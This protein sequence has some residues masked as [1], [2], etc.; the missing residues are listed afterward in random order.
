MARKQARVDRTEP[1]HGLL[2]APGSLSPAGDFSD[3]SK[4]LGMMASI[5]ETPFNERQAEAFARSFTDRTLLIWGPPGTGKTTVLA[6]IVLGWLERAWV[7]NKPICI[8]VGSSNYNAIDKVL[9]DIWEL[10]ARRIERIGP[11]T[12]ATRIVRIRSDSAAPLNEPWVQNLS[13]GELVPVEIDRLLAKP[14]ECLIVGGTWMQ[15]A[16]LA[17]AASPEGEPIAR[18]FDLLILD[19]ASQIKVT[20]A[21]AYYLLLKPTANVVHAG[22]HRQLGPIHGFP[23]REDGEGLFDCIFT[24]L[25]RTHGLQPVA[26]NQNYRTNREISDWPRERFYNSGY[27][28]FVPRRR[29]DLTFPISRSGAPADW[30]ESLPWSEVYYR[31]LDPELP[32]VVVRYEAQTFTLSNPFEA[33]QV[34][35]LTHLYRLLL[36]EQDG[37]GLLD[38]FWKERLGIVTPHRAQMSGIRNLI[39]N[40]AGLPRDQP[41]AVDTVDRFQG[42]ERDVIIASYAVSDRDF[43][44]SEEEFILDPRRFNVTL[45]RARSKFVMFISDALIEHLPSDAQL[46]RDAAHLQLFVENYC[47]TVDEPIELPFL[48]SEQVVIMRCR[49]KGRRLPEVNAARFR[50]D[51][52]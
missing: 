50:G 1:A 52:R 39:I 42:Q 8:G 43:V 9:R 16:K 37:Q 46:A 28:A 36:A 6:G 31:I 47:S 20:T 27:E 38:T 22:D 19:E 24:F 10:I 35:A 45:T 41:P 51:A 23:M 15:L 30:P 2:H 21:A 48:S 12:V 34:A 26:L 29:L 40:V 17:K 13:R 25:Q 7:A 5:L 33:Q 14:S 18:W 4:L 32:V 11:P 49:L 44:R 3:P